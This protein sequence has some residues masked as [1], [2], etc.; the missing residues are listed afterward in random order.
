MLGRHDVREVRGPDGQSVF[1]G[2]HVGEVPS[3]REEGLVGVS[4]WEA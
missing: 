2:F 4:A 1:H 3:V